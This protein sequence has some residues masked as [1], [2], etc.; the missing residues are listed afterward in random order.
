MFPIMIFSLTFIIIILESKSSEKFVTRITFACFGIVTFFFLVIFL[1]ICVDFTYIFYVL[2][3]FLFQLKFEYFDIKV[4]DGCHDPFVT[5]TAIT[6]PLLERVFQSFRV[7]EHFTYF[8][9]KFELEKGV[10][11]LD[12][13]LGEFRFDWVVAVVRLVWLF[14]VEQQTLTLVG[15]AD[16]S[17]VRQR[18]QRTVAQWGRSVATLLAAQT[19]HQG[20][21]GWT[22]Q[23]RLETGFIRY[24]VLIM[25]NTERRHERGTSHHTAY[26]VLHEL[27]DAIDI[28]V[29]L[30]FWKY[31]GQ[32]VHDF[33]S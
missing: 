11:L 4:W 16:A 29:D 14:V 28:L 30:L 6:H 19:A 26:D 18:S 7:V 22:N 20:L 13:E 15:S 21:H 31:V 1:N 5:Q 8:E 27:L 25:Q 2:L 24:S 17:S 12:V 23:C 9:L 32:G 10:W 3:I 33:V